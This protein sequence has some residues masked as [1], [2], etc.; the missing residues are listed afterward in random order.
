MSIALFFLALFSIIFF[1]IR[2]INKGGIV[3]NMVTVSL[4]VIFVLFV[5]GMIDKTTLLSGFFGNGS[6]VPWEIVVLFFSAAYV[7]ISTD[8]SGVFDWVAAQAIKVVDGS[9]WK[10]FVFIFVF[11]SVLTILTSNDIVILTLTPIVFYLS[12]YAKV[13]VIPLLFAQ[14][15]AANTASMFFLIGNP[16]N[17]I[18]ANALDVNFWEYVQVMGLPTIVTLFVLFALLII[19]FGPQITHRFEL[20]RSIHFFLPSKVN[21][22][23]SSV[24]LVGMLVSLSVAH[25]LNLPLWFVALFFATVML[26]KD[27]LR[28]FIH[29][30]IQKRQERNYF[31]QWFEKEYDGVLAVMKRMPFQFFFFLMAMFILVSGLKEVGVVAWMAQG[32]ALHMSDLFS[33]IFSMG[34]ISTVIANLVNNQP[35]TIFF[36][37]VIT[38]ETYRALPSLWQEGSAYALIIGSNLGANLSLFGALAGLMWSAILK[39][40]KILISYKDFLGKGII[41]VPITLCASLLTLVFVL[42]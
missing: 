4:A 29:D 19:L 28:Q 21:A 7:S 23:V 26:G 6:I 33:S 42:Q 36:S 22:L 32:L 14:F 30:H 3:L 27:L 37:Y 12:H 15:Y 17:I 31:Y 18:V 20:K 40:K 35:M 11:S 34:I 39:E 25:L 16:T 41:I 13:N 1:A 38:S 10:L 2:P 5:W 9:G 8:A 24:L